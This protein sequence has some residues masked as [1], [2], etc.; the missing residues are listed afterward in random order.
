MDMHDIA[1]HSTCRIH[2]FTCPYWLVWTCSLTSMATPLEVIMVSVSWWCWSKVTCKNVD[3]TLCN[4]CYGCDRVMALIVHFYLWPM[5]CPGVQWVS[6][7]NLLGIFY[8]AMQKLFI[9]TVLHKDPRGSC[10]TLTLVIKSSLLGFLHRQ[11]HYEHTYQCWYH[12]KV[13]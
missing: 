4:L 2:P 10:A 13:T 1:H 12:K 3:Q 8:A 5:R 9:N 11:L 7:D 6:Y